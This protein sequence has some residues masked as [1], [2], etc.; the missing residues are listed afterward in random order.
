MFTQ[1]I[2]FLQAIPL[3]QNLDNNKFSTL[4]P[5]FHVQKFEKD[6][7]IIVDNSEKDFFYIIYEGKVEIYKEYEDYKEVLAIK[8]AGEFFG[9]MAFIDNFKR[10]ASVKAKTD[11]IL[12]SLD[13]SGFFKI[14]SF[15]EVTIAILRNITKDLRNQ[16]NTYVKK[17][18]NEIDSLKKS[19][20]NLLLKE[21]EN[22]LYDILIKYL[23]EMKN[24]IT[25]I[26]GLLEL[27]Q[28]L[29]LDIQEKE[30][31][32]H[33]LKHEIKVIE[34]TISDLLFYS[35]NNYKYNYTKIYTNNLFTDIIENI[36]NY[37]K[38][39]NIKIIADNK[40]KN[41]KLFVDEKYISKSIIHLIK[42]LISIAES[43]KN[44]ILEINFYNNHNQF[45]IDLM[46]H[47][48]YIPFESD[49]IIFNY[50]DVN[51]LSDNFNSFDLPISTKIISDHKGL[52]K[53][54]NKNNQSILNISLP[55]LH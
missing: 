32:F 38:N 42:Y 46:M 50:D 27:Y 13:K 19:Q 3:F 11:V 49:E 5:Y 29:D 15:P 21:K 9:E 41:E 52:I 25:V 8:E 28:K 1:Y 7:L 31:I 12:I 18:K 48:I 34:E 30:E 23:Y 17:L 39:L 20:I 43:K 14:L 36:K 6:S 37:T 33:S 51:F 10:S 40:C 35:K 44:K 54:Q 24:P 2:E 53:L 45:N 47:G 55:L 4:L 16:N 26:N 22:I